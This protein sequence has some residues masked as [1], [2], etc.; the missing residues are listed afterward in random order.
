MPLEDTSSAGDRVV[1]GGSGKRMLL[2]VGAVEMLDWPSEDETLA[3]RAKP[4]AREMMGAGEGPASATSNEAGEARP[5]IAMGEMALEGSR[6]RIAMGD[7]A[8]LEGFVS[9]DMI[10]RREAGGLRTTL[11]TIQPLVLGFGLRVLPYTVYHQS[12]QLCLRRIG[13]L[14]SS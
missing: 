5:I 6:E 10:A 3:A 1:W 7:T 12:I 13:R 11:F 4:V 2:G 9:G 8:A 14:F